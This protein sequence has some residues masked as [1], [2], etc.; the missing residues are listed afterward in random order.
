MN[1]ARTIHNRVLQDS[2]VAVWSI[3]STADFDGDGKSD[4]L[5]TTAAGGVA[6][7]GMDG[8]Q[9]ARNRVLQTSAVPG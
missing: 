2:G 1:G 9:I 6:I 3:I 4:I 5:W 7:W 8:D